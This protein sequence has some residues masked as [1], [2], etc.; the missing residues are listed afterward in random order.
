[1]GAGALA[2]AS[3]HR[4]RGVRAGGVANDGGGGPAH[5][6]PVLD[7]G[8]AN[9][10]HRAARSLGARGGAARIGPWSSCV[11]RAC[12]AQPSRDS[13][14]SCGDRRA[15][16]ARIARVVASSATHSLSSLV[17]VMGRWGRVG[18]SCNAGCVLCAPLHPPPHRMRRH[19]SR[20]ARCSI[21]PCRMCSLCL[22][23]FVH[24]GAAPRARL[25]R[26]A[27]QR[28]VYARVFRS[29]V[30][31]TVPGRRIGAVRWLRYVQ[32]YTD[33]SMLGQVY[34]RRLGIAN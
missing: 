1:M 7:L 24:V 6:R 18:A 25:H 9:A 20:Y 27:G 12:A 26:A 22:C 21:A 19:A 11:W 34:P 14:R 15:P 17:I 3:A 16:D 30:R 31:A 4:G 5:C 29:G 33:Q 32:L 28:P 8:C 10:A 2:R 23:S 13:P